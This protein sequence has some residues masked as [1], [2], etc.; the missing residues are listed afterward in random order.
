MHATCPSHL[1]L[2]H[3][4]STIRFGE[5]YR[6]W[7]SSICNFLNA[8]F[9]SSLFGTHSVSKHPMSKQAVKLEDVE[10]TVL[11]PL[12]ECHFNVRNSATVAVGHVFDN[13]IAEILRGPCTVFVYLK[14]HRIPPCCQCLRSLHLT[15]LSLRVLIIDTHLS[16]W[17]QHFQYPQN[18][19]PAVTHFQ[20]EYHHSH[21]QLKPPSSSIN[22]SWSLRQSRGTIAPR[23][24][25]RHWYYSAQCSHSLVF[26]RLLHFL[27]L[28]R[29]LG[30]RRLIILDGSTS[31]GW[32]SQ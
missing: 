3:L 15:V 9:N 26:L 5:E 30:I 14:F 32:N 16:C 21:S 27:F 19:W 1:L 20:R 4:I 6:S 2:L 23:P 18:L 25:C 7:N 22:R 31:G 17:R 24:I 29:S 8:P 12:H 10:W 13:D 11:K 28:F